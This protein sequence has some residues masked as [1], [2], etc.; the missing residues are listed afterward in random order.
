M[1]INNT[2]T[3]SYL[4][5]AFFC[6]FYSLESVLAQIFHTYTTFTIAFL[7]KYTCH[8]SNFGDKLLTIM[9]NNRLVFCYDH[10]KRF[11][12]MNLNAVFPVVVSM[13]PMLKGPTLILNISK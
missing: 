12:T 13:L 9:I 6:M 4:K 10:K 8:Y 11:P 1:R 7:G 5:N 3:Y 2:Q